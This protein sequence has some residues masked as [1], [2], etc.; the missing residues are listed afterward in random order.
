MLTLLSLA[1]DHPDAA[2]MLIALHAQQG[3]DASATDALPAEVRAR[4]TDQS[5]AGFAAL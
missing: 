2:E 3:Q 4:L 1:L 5:V